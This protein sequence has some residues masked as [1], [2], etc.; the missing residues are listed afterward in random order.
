MHS[1]SDIEFWQAR[2]SLVSTS[3]ADGSSLDLPEIVQLYYLAGLPHYNEWG[4]GASTL[5]VCHYPTYSL[6]PTPIMRALLHDLIQWVGQNLSPADSSFPGLTLGSLVA[7]EKIEA[8]R[9][10]GCGCPTTEKS[11]TCKESERCNCLR[12]HY[13]IR[14]PLNDEDGN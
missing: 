7:P 12:G 13:P 11:V 6:S 2:S 10:Q 3:T 9:Y 14:V 1:D 5:L 8:S 4:E